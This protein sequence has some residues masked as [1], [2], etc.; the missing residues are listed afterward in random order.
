MLGFSIPVLLKTAFQ[1]IV[2]LKHTNR[3]Y[4]LSGLLF[5]RISL[6]SAYRKIVGFFFVTFIACPIIGPLERLSSGIYNSIVYRSPFA[7]I[8]IGHYQ[9]KKFSGTRKIPSFAVST[10]PGRSRSIRRNLCKN[11]V[12]IQ[13]PHSGI[14]HKTAFVLFIQD[15]W[16]VNFFP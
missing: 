11:P 6:L 2:K 12:R 1:C 5:L 13:C 7:F 16:Y 14:A 4:S 8:I 10:A 15:T 3:T 9:L